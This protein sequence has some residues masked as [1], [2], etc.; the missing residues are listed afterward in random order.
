MP[1]ADRLSSEAFYKAMREGTIERICKV[2]K[3]T[4]HGPEKLWTKEIT[5]VSTDSRKI[6]EGCL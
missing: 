4:Y 2:C 5:A 3:G 1:Q 6:E